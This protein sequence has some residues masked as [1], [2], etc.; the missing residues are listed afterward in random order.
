M[1]ADTASAQTGAGSSF[2]QHLAHLL[3]WLPSLATVLLRLVCLG[4]FMASPY[5]LP[6]GGDR[7]LY[8]HLAI[9]IA[10]GH[11]VEGVFTCMPLYPY[12]L[13]GL[14][15][16]V[17]GAN[18]AAVAI[19]QALL[20]GLTARLIFGLAQR[21]YSRTAAVMAASGFALLG[22]A[23]TYSLVTMPVS[24]GLFWL[25]L[26]ATCVD[27]WQNRWTWIKAGFTGL[28]FGVGGQILGAFWLMIPVVAIWIAVSRP[29]RPYFQRIVQGVLVLGLGYACLAPSL[30]HNF[31]ASREWIPVSAHT[32]LN[33]Y[34]GNNPASA[35]Y[36]AALPGARLSAEEMTRDSVRLA[37]RIAGRPLSLAAANRF[38]QAQARQFWM[39]NPARALRL[40]ARKIQ[41][42]VSIR[43]F[44]DTG[45]CRLLPPMVA[46]LK[47]AA[48]GFGLVWLLACAGY[49]LRP[50]SR[51]SPG[52]WIMGLCLAGG[53]FITFVTA[54]YRLPLAVLLLPAA[55]G[56]LAA[57]PGL[58][59]VTRQICWPRLL[60]G[61]AGCLLAILPHTLPDTALVDSLNQSAY[62]HQQGNST[63]ALA[64][65]QE[66]QN[67][68]PNSVDAWFALGNARLLKNNYAIALDAFQR[69]LTAQPERTDAL[70]N[71]GLALEYLG[72]KT[73]AQ[74]C[75]EQATV[76]D[77]QHAK[78]WFALAILRRDRGETKQARQALTEAARLV[79][80]DHPDI[81]KFCPTQTR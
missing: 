61:W 6:L 5:F 70:F 32:G 67:I 43:E 55:G 40:L 18:L 73:E 81:V 68:Q 47:L 56:T 10:Q 51:S 39:Q 36:G 79:G 34:M 15:M 4:E 49:G 31:R 37:A 27:Q 57:L 24:L 20:D 29:P 14:Y 71:A 69:V 60:A 63:K 9:G 28:I 33:I 2:Q 16:L 7:G 38:W 19:F 11:G 44:D 22:P 23:A 1:S 76:L 65:A 21:R 66:A 42:L 77:A 64:Y 59:R 50:S 41:R 3:P 8:H 78:A 62:W 25:A 17:G 12:L 45:L 80:W 26:A 74:T 35:G 46:P 75:Y 30:I 58:F 13:G 54:R 52:S 72:R 53:V 48:V